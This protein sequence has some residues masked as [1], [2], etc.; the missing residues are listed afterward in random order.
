MAMGLILAGCGGG[1]SS[2][3][4]AA[5]KIVEANLNEQVDQ[6]GGAATSVARFV[7]GSGANWAVYNMADRLVAT[8]VA[9]TKGPIYE[10]ST[11]SFI[12]DI[13]IVTYGGT[14]YALLALGRG[15]IGV[16]DL[17]DPANMT[18]RYTVNVNYEQTGISFTEGGGDILTDQT[19][20][21]ADAPISSLVTDGTTLWIG[22]EG[23][24]IHETALSN[25]IGAAPVKESDGTLKI[26]AETYTLQYAGEN[27]WGGPLDLKLV[28]GKLYA[29][30][31]FLGIGIY[32]PTTL[33]RDGGYNIYTDASV[34]EDWEVNKS[35]ASQVQSPTADYTDPVT[36]M[37]NYKQAAFEINQVWRDGVSAATPWADFDRYGKYYYNARKLDVATVGAETYVYIAYGLGGLVAV[38]ATNPANIQYLGYAPAVPAH[39]PEKA[40]GQ[41]SQSIFPHFGSGMLKEAGVVDVKVDTATDK[42]YYADH[43]A[44][45]VVLDHASTPAANWHGPAG[46]NAYDNN[47]M[48][49]LG[50]HWPDYEFVT[51]YDMSPSDPT[52]EESLPKWLTEAPAMLATGEISGHGGAMFLMPT[53]DNATGNVDI[54]QT[55]G[56]GGVNFIDLGNLGAAAMADRF[57]APVYFPTTSEVGA[58]ADGSATQAMS[59]GHTG[60]VTADD[61]FLYVADGPH[62]MSIWRIADDSGKPIDDP[63]VVANTVQSEGTVTVGGADILPTPH[64][65]QV[66]MGTAGNDAYVMSQ[67][68]G[69]RR[70]NVAGVKSGNGAVGAPLL[71]APSASDVYEHSLETGKVGGIKGQDH[72][73]DMVVY[74]HYGVVAD[75]SNGLTVYDLSVD[76]TT[77]TQVVANIGAASG[78][79]E[80]GRAQAV[81]LW[82]DSATGKVYA[83]VAAG[84][85]GIGVV[86]MTDLLVNGQTP[87]M[88]L[89][90]LFEPIK[91]E[92]DH[93]G[94][95]DGHS[96]DIEVVGDYAYVSYD[97]FGIVC[98][99]IADLIAPL[100]TGIAPTEV[101]DKGGT[102]DYRPVAVSRFRLQE[103]PGF[104]TADGTAQYMTPQYFPADRLLMDENGKVYVLDKPKLFFYVAYGASG[105]VKLDWIDPANPVLL[106]HKETVGTAVDT[107]IAN[108]RVY[109][110]DSDGGVAIFK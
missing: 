25:L 105:V 6:I 21:S 51:S 27:P 78:Q 18:L 65:Y 106:Q 59:V 88:N 66:I 60:G 28:G 23:Y 110:A 12:K 53:I 2:K 94:A 93:V 47:T 40:T 82:T 70:V 55:T 102:Y 24:G 34:T 20:S 62:G 1:G 3:D 95:A 29:A 54:V 5:E 92:A 101:W 36:G 107:A 46:A 69:V 67:S 41:Q 108:G 10:I 85:S 38:N 7:D 13:E 43:F 87:G 98:Y 83:L 84:S 15:G 100:P 58:A 97:S 39:G 31:G 9:T 64:A 91:T 74:G 14:R 49:S 37:P 56:A 103:Q 73:Y 77:G 4:L 96:V 52:E 22:D 99:R 50:D 68:L 86:D 81:K 80:V 8:Q 71:L 63:H 26:D 33:A 42:V 45:L 17:S 48:G 109:A 89:V 75:G 16:V 44:G 32:N 11:G 61:H 19:I 72:A 35:V 30:L 79:P 57:S 104:E 76:P 90:K